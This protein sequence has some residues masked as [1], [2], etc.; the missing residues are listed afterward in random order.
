MP[1]ASIH[2]ITRQ[3]FLTTVCLIGPHSPATPEVPPAPLSPVTNYSYSRTPSPI[4]GL[5][6]PSELPPALSRF[7]SFLRAG[8]ELTHQGSIPRTLTQ[9][10]IADDWDFYLPFRQLAPSKRIVLEDPQGPF[11][12]TMLRTRE[13]LFDALIFRLITQASPFLLQQRQVCFGSPSAFEHAVEGMDKRLYCNPRATGRHNRLRNIPHI[14]SYWERT[15]DWGD[16]IGHGVTLESL[17]GWFIGNMEGGGTRFFGMGYLVGWLLASDYAYAGL[18]NEPSM[19]EV[20]RVIFKIDAGGKAGL[21]LLGLGVG[22]A[23]ACATSLSDLW[24]VILA[25]FTR[26]EI[27]EMGLDPITLEHALCKYKRL[28]KVIERVSGDPSLPRVRNDGLKISPFF[29]S[30]S[31]TLTLYL[32]PIIGWNTRSNLISDANIKGLW[33]GILANLYK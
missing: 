4:P 3:L 18:V 7:I 22:T 27:N 9:K 12:P 26:A 15:E 32:Y 21:A 30:G 19:S 25:Q 24:D 16:L 23:E 8:F 29:D 11:S 28:W 6:A 17:L 13:G 20:G 14:S 10:K 5:P 31:R 2:L 1:D 33:S